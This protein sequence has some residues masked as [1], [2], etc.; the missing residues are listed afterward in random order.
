MGF[1]T[2]DAWID[3]AVIWG[4]TMEFDAPMTP[5]QFEKFWGNLSEDIQLKRLF[6]S[7]RGNPFPW[8]S[9]SVLRPKPKSKRNHLF[10]RAAIEV[11]DRRTRP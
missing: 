11:I 9:R 6:E 1:N 3:E 8:P 2:T 5:K 4:L 7:L 10:V